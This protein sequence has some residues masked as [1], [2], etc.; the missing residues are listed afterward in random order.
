MPAAR[1]PIMPLSEIISASDAPKFRKALLLWFVKH[2]RPMPWRE[3]VSAYRTVVSELMCQQT[4]IA[5]VIPYFNRW[6]K[7]WPD[8]K[9][10][11]RSKE[12]EVL[13][14]WAGL[15][16]YNRARNLRACAMEVS[17]LKALPTTATE[18]QKFKGIGPYTAA[19]IAS[20]AYHEAVAV[21]DGNVVRVLARLAGVKKV[22]S[23][24]STAVKYFTS[25]ANHLVDTRQPGNFNQAMMELGAMV[26]R[27][28]NPSCSTC[29]VA[30]WCRAKKDNTAES[31]PRFAPKK[32]QQAVV[33]R[34]LIFDKNKLLLHRN[35]GDA[36][37]LAGMAEIPETGF[38]DNKFKSQKSWIR[39]RT[40]G[41]VTYEENINLITLDKVVGAKIKQYRSLEWI[42]LKNL[43]N[44]AITGP[45]LRWIEE[46]INLSDRTAHGKSP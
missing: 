18:W 31:L 5:T 33:H 20:I 39:R 42:A 36:K 16:Y 9:D 19:A 11:A 21:V 2:Q 6:V 13:A 4:Q 17:R 41:S 26:C 22:F 35:P 43:K 38:L 28:S 29:P 24:G 1:M 32:R 3:K 25:L 27:K 30:Q 40:I 7:K 15:G 12:S 23:D 10:L 37:R 34:A 44:A 14:N 46:W 8:F 45:H